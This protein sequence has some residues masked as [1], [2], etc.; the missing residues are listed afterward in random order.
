MR[1]EQGS[2]SINYR[3]APPLPSRGTFKGPCSVV[4]WAGTS[5]AINFTFCFVSLLE[6][7]GGGGVGNVFL[8][9]LTFPCL[10]LLDWRHE[11]PRHSFSVSKI[12]DYWSF[13]SLFLP[14]SYPRDNAI[15][16][17]W[18]Q[19]VCRFGRKVI[20]GRDW[21]LWEVRLDSVSFSSDG[22]TNWNISEILTS[23]PFTPFACPSIP[24]FLF[25]RVVVLQDVFGLLHRLASVV[26]V[27]ENRWIGKF[28][29]WT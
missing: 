23:C 22:F 4:G 13:E 19:G 11:K 20:D 8:C 27:V 18:S 17:G 12:R 24:L 16:K 21:A 6:V 2:L 7:G 14:L 10:E 25:R 15:I 1:V 28:Q 29:C 3:S 26:V 5:P 9:F